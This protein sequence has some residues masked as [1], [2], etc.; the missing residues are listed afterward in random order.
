MG[1]VWEWT[2]S[3]FEPWPGFR[4]M[5]Y[6]DYSAPFFGGDYRVLRGGAWSVGGVGGAAVV[7]QLGP[8]GPAADL[9]RRSGWPGMCRHLAWLG[10]PRTLAS[11]VLE[12][13]HGLLRQ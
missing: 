13:E 3:A 4:P 2:S 1:D 7:P 10:E 9:Q 5:L 8:P 12:P 11:L 6:A